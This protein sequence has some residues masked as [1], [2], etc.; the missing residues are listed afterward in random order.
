MF[1]NSASS[2]IKSASVPWN[3]LSLP[4]LTLDSLGHYL[5]ALG[6]LVILNRRWPAVRGCWRQGRFV[7]VNGPADQDELIKQLAAVATD[8]KW[9]DYQKN[10][11]KALKEDTNGESSD[12]SSLWRSHQA[13]EKFLPVFHAHLALADRLSFNPLF[14]TG[15]N[16][17]QRDFSKGWK[18][19]VDDLKEPPRRWSKY[20]LLRDLEAFL[21]GE[22]CHC[23]NGYNAACWFSASNKVFN[24]GTKNLSER[25][26]SHL[27][28]WCWPAKRFHFCVAALRGNWGANGVL[29]VLSHLLHNQRQWMRLESVAISQVKFGCRFGNDRW[30]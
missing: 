29:Q 23:L 24:S 27:G 15:G 8:G 6:L 25:V 2:V 3:V 5:A 16:S 4:G 17:G 18:E 14:G 10:W 28:P 30:L 13:N 20:M 1:P 7:L 9:M 19:V 22:S 11:D 21:R 26:K 12:K